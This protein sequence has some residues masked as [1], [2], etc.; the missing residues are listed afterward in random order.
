MSHSEDPCCSLSIEKQAYHFS[1]TQPQAQLSPSSPPPMLPSAPS[2]LPLPCHSPQPVPPFASPGPPPTQQFQSG[3]P[4]L[5][6]AHNVMTLISSGNASTQHVVQQVSQMA[7]RYEKPFKLHFI[8]GNIS[9]CAGCKGKYMKPAVPPFNLC[10]QHE[11]WRQITY[12]NSPAPSSVF[13]NAYYHPSLHCL[14]VN[15]PGF[16]GEHLVIPERTKSALTQEYWRILEQE[17]GVHP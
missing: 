7:Y 15:W 3:P 8:T 16:S 6:P 11:E 13:S 2:P 1:I 17:L 10:I 4:P 12:S 9:K 5:V 14:S